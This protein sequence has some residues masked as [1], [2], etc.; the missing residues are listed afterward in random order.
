MPIPFK[1]ITLDRPYKLRCELGAANEFEDLSGKSVASLTAN[2]TS[3]TCTLLL[4]IMLKDHES[5]P[6]CENMTL[7]DVKKLVSDYSPSLNYVMETVIAAVKAGFEGDSEA[8]K[9]VQPT[10]NKSQTSTGSKK[11]LPPLSGN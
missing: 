7:A 1:M 4:W 8:P 3:N 6:G 2:I 9:N 5:N 10:A 11:N